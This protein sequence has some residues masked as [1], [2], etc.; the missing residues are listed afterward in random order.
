MPVSKLEFGAHLPASGLPGAERRPRPMLAAR[1]SL[2]PVD[3][4]R[5]ASDDVR[6]GS[7][8]DIRACVD[9]VRFT[10][11]SGHAPSRQKCPLSAKSGHW[12]IR[13]EH[14]FEGEKGARS[15]GL[16]RRPKCQRSAISVQRRS[17]SR[18]IGDV[19]GMRQVW[20]ARPAKCSPY[21]VSSGFAQQLTGARSRNAYCEM[22]K[23]WTTLIAAVVFAGGASTVAF[24]DGYEPSGKG[25][26][27]PPS[28]NW[29]GLYVGLSV[30][31]AGTDVDWAF[32]PGKPPPAPNQAFSF[33]EDETAVGGQ[34]GY[35]HQFGAIVV[36]IEAAGRAFPDNEFSLHN[37][38]G[39]NFNEFAASRVK[40]LFTIGGRLGYACSS[41][42][43]LYATG[44]F[45]TAK[46]ETAAFE[47]VPFG[48]NPELN[49]DERHNG[50]YVGGGIEHEFAR[51]VVFGI[52]Y[53]RV[54]LDTELHRTPLNPQFNNHD[55][56]ADIDLV[57]ARLIIKLGK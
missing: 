43:L 29:T 51:N 56:S 11:R 46:V 31:W 24:A 9:Y 5:V 38:Y 41:R 47:K 34:V 1:S 49:T 20:R 23:Y 21:N 52:D 16:D 32:N 8:A 30:G 55:I 2:E 6:F 14:A 37:G 26:A 3:D 39:G 13:A 35:Q 48:L 18:T 57:T 10:P 45:A 33:T 25:F 17:A 42:W 27:P 4:S 28:A 50:W 54:D 53:Q 12:S 7:K 15:E 36:G 22:S 40:D 44:G 19:A